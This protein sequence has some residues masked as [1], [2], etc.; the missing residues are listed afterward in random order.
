MKKLL[1]ILLL[2]I[3]LF[4]VSCDKPGDKIHGRFVIIERI[5]TDTYLVYDEETKV[6]YYLNTGDFLSPYYN[7]DG[8]VAVYVD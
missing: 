3:T 8:T 2:F 5:Y 7:A 6:I 1:L 4:C